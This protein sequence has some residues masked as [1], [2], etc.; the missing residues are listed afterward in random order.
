MV[1]HQLPKLTMGVRFP[2]GAPFIMK[3]G[4]LLLFGALLTSSLALSGCFSFFIP[5]GEDSQITPPSI[6]VV[7]TL[8]INLQGIKEKTLQPSLSGSSAKNSV[9]EYSSSNS[10]IATVDSSG[11]VTGIS[12]GT[13]SITIVLQSNKTVKTTVTVSV[14]DEEVDHYDYT[15]MYYMCG[16]DLEYSA[17]AK[18]ENEHGFFTKDIQEILSVQ[19]IP[20]SVRI[21]IET[22]GTTH[23]FMP[24]SYLEGATEISSKKLQRWE[25]NNETHKLKL[26]QTL[27]TNEMAKQE[28][29]EDFL[30]WGL[31]EYEADQM[32]VVISG[33][34]GGIAG[35]AYDDNYTYTYGRYEYANTLQTYEIANAAKLALANSSKD[36]FTWIGYDCCVM[37]CADIAT[38]NSDYFEY[39][40]ASQ[41][42]EDAIGW[43]HDVYLPYLVANPNISPSSFLPKICD[44]FLLDKH[45]ISERYACLQ[46]LSVLDLSKVNSLITTFESIVPKLGSLSIAYNRAKT[47]FE[48]SYNDFGEGM[49]GLCDFSSLLEQI[50][51]KYSINTTAAINAVNDLVLYKTNCSHY[52]SI[53]CGVNAF[54]PDYVSSDREYD[55]QV[56]REDYEN[57]N[58]TKFNLWQ[59]LCLSGDGFGW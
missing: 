23:W 36:K 42:L 24:S 38:I 10:A 37:Q 35:C 49:Y 14:V 1:E 52:S 28:S 19:N 55:L 11:V 22:G 40:V 2:S 4:K 16:S 56:G 9:F 41:E 43:N 33:H 29:F 45:T 21:I 20:D 7:P 15:I 26:I 17:K 6:D 30:S 31:D 27:S 46:T 13:C 5:N 53:P 39:M 47:A 57:I 8:K 12:V 50:Q 48:A 59:A 25:V 34:G 32:G 44:S 3:K 58:S 51:L 54:F 18:S